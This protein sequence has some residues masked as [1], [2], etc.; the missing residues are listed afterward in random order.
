MPKRKLPEPQGGS[1]A[2]SEPRQQIA[3]CTSLD[4]V[5]EQL[6]RAK[7]VVVRWSGHL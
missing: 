5:V 1:E 3:S 6:Q 7:N 4:D 2:E